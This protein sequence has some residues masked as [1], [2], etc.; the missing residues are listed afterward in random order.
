MLYHSKS[1]NETIEIANELAQTLK[2]G[3]VLALIG[4]LGSGKTTFM[5]GLAKGLGI[6]KNITSPTFVITKI[7]KDGRLNLLHC[8]CYRLSGEDDAISI[9]LLEYFDKTD[10]IVA[11]E[12]PEKIEE[13]LP[14]RLKKIK[15]SYI[16]ESERTIEIE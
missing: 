14:E 12:W 3:D 7:Y 16:S 5:K 10:Y 15:F 1:E 4:D 8:D 2:G 9:G 6:S 13:I 11:L